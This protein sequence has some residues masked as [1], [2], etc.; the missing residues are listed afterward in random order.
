RSPPGPEGLSAP[1]ASA[2]WAVTPM[3]GDN[4]YL[5]DGCH[6]RLWVALPTNAGR[7]ASQLSRRRVGQL[8]DLQ[9]ALTGDHLGSSGNRERGLEVADQRTLIGAAGQQDA[10]GSEVA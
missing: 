6:R 4:Y 9:T 8:H 7:P 1:N 10:G 2:L 5:T 3:P